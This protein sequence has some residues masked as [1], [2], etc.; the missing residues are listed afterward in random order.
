MQ[1]G[2]T[3]QIQRGQRG[4]WW[5]VEEIVVTH[6]ACEFLV[7][8]CIESA[9]VLTGMLA[10]Q[11]LRWHSCQRRSARIVKVLVAHLV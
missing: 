7:A 2:L 5:T 8:G 10:P 6:A 11:Q 1:D 3:W 4:T 9:N